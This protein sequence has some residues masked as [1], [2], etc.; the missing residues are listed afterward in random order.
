MDWL[1]GPAWDRVSFSD[2][3]SED[4]GELYREM[5]RD[6]I[7]TSDLNRRL[8]HEALNALIVILRGFSTWPGDR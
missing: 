5:P 4:D 2:T 6:I 8:D 7:R 1:H 3:E